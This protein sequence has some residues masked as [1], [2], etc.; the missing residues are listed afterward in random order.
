MRVV[1]PELVGL[2]EA[3]GQLAYALDELRGALAE[4]IGHRRRQ[5]ELVL[6]IALR[7]YRATSVLSHHVWDN[8]IWMRVLSQ[9]G[10]WVRREL[11]L[12]REGT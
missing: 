9:P 6:V 3:I 4:Q 2:R 5:L 8:S 10:Q 11:I 12:M 7:Q 1:D